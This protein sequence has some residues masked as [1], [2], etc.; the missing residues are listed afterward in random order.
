MMAATSQA[1]ISIL[2]SRPLLE[3]FRQSIGA[4][5]GIVITEFVDSLVDDDDEDIKDDAFVEDDIFVADD[6]VVAED[7]VDEAL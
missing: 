1:V 6:V 4:F 7:V 2:L 3:L 5:A